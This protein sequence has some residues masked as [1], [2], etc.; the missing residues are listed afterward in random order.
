[1]LSDVDGGM[2]ASSLEV[3]RTAWSLVLV[4]DLHLRCD[5]TCC[6]GVGTKGESTRS[7][8]DEQE[9]PYLSMKRDSSSAW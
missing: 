6:R 7:G 5:I 2:I 3:G 9:R 1:M 4:E 8:L